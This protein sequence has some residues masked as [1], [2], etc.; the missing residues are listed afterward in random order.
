[1]TTQPVTQSV[2]LLA[3][4]LPKLPE[5]PWFLMPAATSPKNV[6]A[7]DSPFMA[8]VWGSL[9]ITAA[10]VYAMWRFSTKYRAKSRAANEVPPADH[11]HHTTLEIVWS[12]IPLFVVIGLFVWGF[13]GFVMMRTAPKEA[14]EIQAQGQKWKWLYTYPGG[15]VDDAM[16]VPPDENIRVVINSVDVLHSL[17]VPAARIKMDAVPG[18]YTSLWFNAEKPGTYPIFCAEYCGTSHSDMLS[19]L[20]VHNT[21]AEYD[22]WLEA[23]NKPPEDPIEHGKLL[24]TKQGCQTCHSVDGSAGTGPTWKAL[25]GKDRPL[26]GGGSAK[27]DENYIK[28]SILQ[29]QA[30]VAEGYGPVMPTYQGKLKDSQIDALIAFI[31]SHK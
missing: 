26:A 15:C 14:Y 1:M 8:M 2:A 5:S 16:H 17:F 4:A 31:K 10:V 19:E 20:V 30:K 22:K 21:R 24:Y 9:A 23:C 13:K 27:V 6:E 28:E 7:V 3:A 12:V 11:G 18:R 29:P 25:W